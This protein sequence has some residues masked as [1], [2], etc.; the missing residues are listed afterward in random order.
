MYT[1]FLVVNALRGL[2]Y[3]KIYISIPKYCVHAVD[4]VV[5][6][7]HFAASADVLDDD[8]YVQYTY[9]DRYMHTGHDITRRLANFVY[10]LH[11]VVSAR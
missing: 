7:S 6:G 2:R 3:T 5:F 1:F 10:G 8:V 9:I 11:F 4:F